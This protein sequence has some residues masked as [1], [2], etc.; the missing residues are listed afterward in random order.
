MDG[1]YQLDGLVLDFFISFK[2]GLSPRE[3]LLYI[4]P[5]ILEDDDALLSFKELLEDLCSK[6][7]IDFQW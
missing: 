3:I 7:I 1:I 6:Q 5:G 2:L 4:A